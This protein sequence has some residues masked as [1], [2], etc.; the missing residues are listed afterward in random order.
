MD[1]TEM[2]SNCIFAN[3]IGPK[4]ATGCE[5]NHKTED[6]PQTRFCDVRQPPNQNK[7]KRTVPLFE[8]V[9]SKSSPKWSSP[10]NTEKSRHF[11]FYLGDPGKVSQNENR[12][13]FSDITQTWPVQQDVPRS[14][15][16]MRFHSWN[17]SE[18][19]LT[20]TS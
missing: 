10:K 16:P 13:Q 12:F 11:Y 4:L 20:A 17:T 15:W 14:R 2:D 9:E 1:K 3:D 6:R 18:V 5:P 19:S 7:E 8:N